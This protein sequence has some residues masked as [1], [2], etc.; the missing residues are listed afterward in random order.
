MGLY[1]H[2]NILGLHLTGMGLLGSTMIFWLC[3]TINALLFST[4]GR[5]DSVSPLI[6]TKTLNYG[7]YQTFTYFISNERL[8]WTDFYLPYPANWI[9]GSTPCFSYDQPWLYNRTF[10]QVGGLPLWFQFRSHHP[11]LQKG[12][13]F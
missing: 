5:V 9:L 12:M 10:N 2:R 6:K 3:F 13:V 1:I 4:N 8:R 7:R 11:A